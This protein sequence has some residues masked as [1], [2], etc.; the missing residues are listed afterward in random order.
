ML[1]KNN[2][3]MEIINVEVPDWLQRN[4][5]IAITTYFIKG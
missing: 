4:A 5:G 1:N 3:P 2:T